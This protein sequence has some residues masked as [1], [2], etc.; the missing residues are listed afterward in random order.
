[1]DVSE[2][3]PQESWY[4]KSWRPLCGFS[5]AICS[6][7]SIA[8][9]CI[10]MWRIIFNGEDK[11]LDIMEKFASSVVRILVLPGAAAGISAWHRG[12]QQ[13]KATEGAVAINTAAQLGDK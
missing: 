3:I 2:L 4:Q 11:L 10:M 1:M 7:V 12:V 9:I 13:V 8:I 5:V 6:T